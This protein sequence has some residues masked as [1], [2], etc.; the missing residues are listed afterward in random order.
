MK[1]H[2]ALPSRTSP[3]K[4][5]KP[6]KMTRIKY[7]SVLFDM[8]SYKKGEKEINDALDEGY[9]VMRDF[10]TGAGIVVCLGKWENLHC[11]CEECTQ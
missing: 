2:N 9:Q 8:K 10:E 4:K 5:R 3:G 6:E 11:D 1:P 7:V